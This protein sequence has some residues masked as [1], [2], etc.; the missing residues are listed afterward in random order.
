MMNN[1]IH[2]PINPYGIT[3]SFIHCQNIEM[4][5]IKKTI[6]NMPF[7]FDQKFCNIYIFMRY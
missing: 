3:K 7:L 1:I 6:G 4:L 2:N 5:T